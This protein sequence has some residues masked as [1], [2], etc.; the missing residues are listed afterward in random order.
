VDPASFI[1]QAAFSTAAI[2][3][4]PSCGT[5]EASTIH[6][7][8]V[9]QQIANTADGKSRLRYLEAGQGDGFYL[10]QTWTTDAEQA[11]LIFPDLTLEQLQKAGLA[12]SV[13]TSDPGPH[14]VLFSPPL[15]GTAVDL[16]RNTEIRAAL[17]AFAD[18]VH[19]RVHASVLLWGAASQEIETAGRIALTFTTTPSDHERIM[20]LVASKIHTAGVDTWSFASAPATDAS[21]AYQRVC[22]DANVVAQ[23]GRIL[24]PE[25]FPAFAARWLATDLEFDT[26]ETE[27]WNKYLSNIVRLTGVSD[28]SNEQ[29]CGVATK[30]LELS[31]V[32][33]K[34]SEELLAW[35]IAPEEFSRD[36]GSGG[37]LV[38]QLS[39]ALSGSLKPEAAKQVLVSAGHPN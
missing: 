12:V 8:R 9:I 15:S 4:E 34:S 25:A 7:M 37:P 13:D 16:S 36:L 31:G 22:E 3:T 33:R 2:L 32:A 21:T 5:T 23:I 26:Y 18:L 19:G 35:R 10:S 27:R 20:A 11:A 24:P 14:G 6:G 28:V 29:L 30:C 38:Q 1:K 39:A 17:E